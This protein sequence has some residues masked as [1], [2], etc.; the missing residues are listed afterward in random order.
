MT[1][2]PARAKPFEHTFSCF[3]HLLLREAIELQRNV[4]GIFHV[5]QTVLRIFRIK[6]LANTKSSN[7]FTPP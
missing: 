5:P 4:R 1:D 3:T 2:C 7:S 6:S